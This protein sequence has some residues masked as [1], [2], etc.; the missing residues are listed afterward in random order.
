MSEFKKIQEKYIEDRYYQPIIALKPDK[1]ETMI[2]CLDYK[3]FN[4]DVDFI[5]RFSWKDK[6]AI[7]KVIK[8]VMN[9]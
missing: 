1:Y 5:G 2:A 8:A 7:L 3:E 9:S 6:R 4:G